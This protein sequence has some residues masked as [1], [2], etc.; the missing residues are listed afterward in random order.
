MADTSTRIAEV[1]G[2]I[3]R[4][5]FQPGQALTAARE[6]DFTLQAAAQS[7]EAATEN[8]DPNPAVAG[9]A[10]VTALAITGVAAVFVAYHLKRYEQTARQQ[11]MST[12]QSL[13][14]ELY[15]VVERLRGDG[16]IYKRCGEEFETFVDSVVTLRQRLQSQAGMNAPTGPFVIG[17]IDVLEA[18]KADLTNYLIVIDSYDTEEQGDVSV[19]TVGPNGMIVNILRTLRTRF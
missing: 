16:K 1:R 17:M 15:E 14:A 18:I 5:S 13:S 11:L 12:V 6:L 8:D 9:I 19:L 7:V 4:E 2:I 3:Q 10:E